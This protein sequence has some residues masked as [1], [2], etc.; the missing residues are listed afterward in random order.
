VELFNAINCPLSTA[1]A[2][3]HIFGCCIFIFIQSCFFLNFIFF[4]F[5]DIWII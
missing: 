4:F 2:V 3:F 1:L 5:F